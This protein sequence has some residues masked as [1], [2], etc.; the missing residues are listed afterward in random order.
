MRIAL[1][2]ATALAIVIPVAT[3]ADDPLWHKNCPPSGTCFV[4]QFVQ[5]MPQKVVLLHARF[6]PV[7]ADGQSVVTFTVPPGV[8]LG[9][10]LSLSVDGAKPLFLP[11][12]RCPT[13]GCRATA[14]LDKG[15]LNMMKIGKV[16][17]ARYAM[18]ADKGIDIPIRLTGLDDALKSL[19][20]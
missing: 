7:N 15:A 9:G 14:V 5:V 18:T 17:T 2:G 20:K 12:E 16:L 6:D 10:G 8:L 4:E 1:L 3:W 19:S 13:G 11:Y